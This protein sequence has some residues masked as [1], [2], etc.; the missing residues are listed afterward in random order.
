MDE[1]DEQISEYFQGIQDERNR[2]RTGIDKMI[3]NWDENFSQDA[4]R[5]LIYIDGLVEG[6]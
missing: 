1:M 5:M 2:I 6:E 3:D 4:V